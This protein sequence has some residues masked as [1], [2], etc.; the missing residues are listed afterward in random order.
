L[1]LN[2]LDRKLGLADSVF[3]VIGSVFG[4][5]IFLTTGI[6]AGYIPS[7][8]LI[9]SV[10]ILGG[11][12]TLLGALAY[13]E[14][15]TLFPGAGG[16]YIYLREAYGPSVSFLYGWTFFW[17]IGGGGIA[18]LAMGFAEYAGVLVP[19]LSADKLLLDSGLG[20]IKVHLTGAQFTAVFSIVVLSLI[21]LFGVK[22]GVRFQNFMTVL[23][24]LALGAFVAFGLALG[25]HPGLLNLH[26]LFPKGPL[27]S[28]TLFGAAFLAVVWTY[29]GWYSVNC[30][31]EEVRNPQRTIP[32]SLV[33]GTIA[34]T[35]LYL[36][37]NMVYSIA[38][39]VENMRGVVRIGELAALRLFGPGSALF[40]SALIAVAI[41]GCLSANILY[42]PRVSFAMARDGLFFKSLSVV[43]PRQRV[44]SNAILAQMIWSSLLC[45]SGTYQGLIE[46]VA[47]A[48]VL[49][50]AATG[51]SVFVLR[52]KMPE[53]ERP[54]RTW[55]YP[56]LP[57]LY[58]VS[59]LAIFFAVIIAR[60]LQALAGAILIAAGLPAYLLWMKNK[61]IRADGARA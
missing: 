9:C 47:F 41:L 7:P 14:L 57:A 28:W 1:I 58:I 60:P 51:F 20:P 31:A 50:F 61:R 2:E 38:L 35:V 44:P 15:G 56:V 25:R 29:D 55:G 36:M 42:C 39:P 46:Y 10:W 26:P 11:F 54:F 59:N 18:A 49:F 16:P 32:R 19:G 43:H 40:F 27:P 22:S 8:G 23:R 33:L 45:F 17:V 52:R 4:S 48:L 5:G 12:L 24:F 6:I 3:L 34:V 30:A 37:A 53:R 13:A 21:N